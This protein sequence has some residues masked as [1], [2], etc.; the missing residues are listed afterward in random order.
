M[1]IEHT[2]IFR[3]CGL[4]SKVFRIEVEC[5]GITC[6]ISLPLKPGADLNHLF[7]ELNQ[8]YQGEP[9]SIVQDMIDNAWEK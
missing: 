6:E 1:E 4:T 7:A 2:G 5:K 3:K 9:F 8:H